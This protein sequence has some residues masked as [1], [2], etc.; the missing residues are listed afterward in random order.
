[1]KAHEDWLESPRRSDQPDGQVFLPPDKGDAPHLLYLGYQHCSGGHVHSG[2][3]PH[4]LL[5]WVLRGHGHLRLGNQRS[6]LG[7]GDGFLIFPNLP[8][9]YRAD[10]VDPWSYLWLAIG[11]EETIAWLESAGVSAERPVISFAAAAVDMEVFFRNW[12]DRFDTARGDLPALLR[13][14]RSAALDLLGQLDQ[15]A[16]HAGWPRLAPKSPD[17]HAERIRQF[18]EDNYSRPLSTAIIARAVHLDRS[19]CCTV[20]ARAQGKGIMAWLTD[21]RL[22]RA[23]ELL[24]TSPMSLSDIAKSVGIGDSVRFSKNFKAR[25]GISPG[26]WRANFL[27]PE[28]GG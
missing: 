12:L 22:Q 19:H 24:G 25:Y 21:L 16:R 8:F 4:A 20:F 6:S 7:P 13:H 27:H 9:Q 14:S 28:A 18:L 15:A 1:M 3:R 23:A 5:H 11:G 26:K 17:N 2:C 10:A